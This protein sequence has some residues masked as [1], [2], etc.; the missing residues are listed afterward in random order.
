MLQDRQ[1]NPLTGANAEA[2][3]AF[4][5]G[6]RAFNIYRG[7]PLAHADAAL[8]AAP[9]CVMA[10]LLKAH[11]LLM[12]TEPAAAEEAGGILGHVRNLPMSDREA[13]HL[14]ALQQ[15]LAGDWSRGAETLDRL[16]MRYPHDLLALQSGHLM[17]FY[18]GNAR[19]L[20]D[21]VTRVLP[22]WTADVPGY[23]IVLG[24]QA[25]GLEEC[26][27]YARAEAAGR[28]ALAREP[29]DCWAHHAV[30]HVMEMQG[31]AEDGIGWMQVRQAQWDGD[32]NFFKVHNWWHKALFHLD[33][34][35]AEGAL[36]LYDGAVRREASEVAMDL[37][38]A[39]ALLWRLHAAG[40][41]VGGRCLEVAEVWRAHAD[42][43]LYPF[44]DWHAAMAY[45]GADQVVEVDRLIAAYENAPSAGEVGRWQAQIG[46][47][48]L[49]GFRAFATGHYAEAVSD[50]H[51][52]R[53]I[54]NGFGGS[55]AQRDV[56]DWTLAEAAIRAGLGAEAVAFAQERV[57]VK[58]HSP[59]S[60]RSLQRARSISAAPAAAA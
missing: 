3:A 27:D 9:A 29:L 38:D 35:D 58:P 41:D 40:V 44:N 18:R 19:N 39:S 1:G 6:V 53:A 32:D 23:S 42:G 20:R 52:G 49:R 7:D 47:P 33:L 4:D 12:A 56:I 24:F 21:R 50:L 2:V 11:L 54:A 51:T 45:L 22:A 13:G 48:L 55:H 26:G 5:A 14:A 57:A 37:V 34:D 60:R 59:I 15:V 17:D 16:N 8:A 43:K 46:L 31:R 36:A 28:E 30:A 10:H 25:F